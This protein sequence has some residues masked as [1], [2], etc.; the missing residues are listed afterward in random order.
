MG[1]SSGVLLHISSLPGES[2][3]GDMGK[4]AIQFVDFLAQTKQKIWQIL[5]LGPVG[6]GNSPYQCY[7]AFAGNPM[8]IDVHQLATDRLI[9]KN[10]ITDQHFKAKKVEFERV[11]E[12]KMHLFRE[13]FIGFKRN[14][15]RYKD[16]YYT[17]MSHN[18][19]WL[20]DYA[21]FR[22]LKSKNGETVWNTWSKELVTR[23]R[24]AIHNAF[25][26]LHAE[27]D[28]H[29]F[30]QFIFFRQWFKLKKYANSKGIQIIGDI[31]LY[32]SMD[33][34]DV[35]ANQDIFLL[36][37]DAK[38][39]QVGGVPPDY[40]SETGQLWGNPVFDWERVA[41]RDFDWWLA[42][43]SF[44]LRMF[45]QVRVD[46]FR[47][48]ESFWAIPVEE[49]TAIVGEWLPAKG[50]EL[51]RKL[52]EQHGSLNIIA[53]DLGVI[54]PEVERLRDDFNLPGMKILQFAFGS[55]A[56][57]M[58]LPH[59]YTSNFIAYTGTH[60]NDTTLGWFKSIGS[61][62]RRFL[63]KYIDGKGKQFVENFIEQAWA[64]AAHTA[65]IPMQ[66]VLGLDTDARMN[67]PGIAAG[68]W[69]W[70]FTWSQIRTNHKVFLKR[71][72]EKYNR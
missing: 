72:T 17:F 12:W 37:E 48:L 63:H 52:K 50:Y 59:N 35:W 66:D 57:N 25:Q 30:L 62:E 8:F 4:E 24:G 43:V 27:V 47:G 60:D 29:R 23:D 21:L 19:W 9:S 32:V 22:S 69:D 1:R 61:K 28:F 7:S 51:F 45:D 36:D 3:I 54:T 5:P 58:D 44:N 42:R 10:S 20:D 49:E 31:P 38:P 26:E 41:E 13:A 65:I 15:D 34:V 33:S 55:D 53:E 16:D 18:S 56:T 6:Y 68:N 40:F 14:F 70:R 71:V 11:E 39:T 46:H 67:T 2:G 64:S